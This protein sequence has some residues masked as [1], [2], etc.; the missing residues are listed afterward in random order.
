M[1]QMP[2]TT[3]QIIL[4]WEIIGDDQRTHQTAR[5]RRIRMGNQISFTPEKVSISDSHNL[6]ACYLNYFVNPVQWTF[7]YFY[8]MIILLL[9]TSSNWIET[10]DFISLI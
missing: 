6:L 9:N 1:G 4:P 3:V 8:F 5:K 2:E 7:R 10:L